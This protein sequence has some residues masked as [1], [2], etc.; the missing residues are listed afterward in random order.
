MRS[1]CLR[2]LLLLSAV[3]IP[4]HAQVQKKA[5]TQA[6]WDRWESIGAPALSNDGR[7]A[8]YTIRPQVGDGRYVV[9][10]T[11]GTTEYTIPL[12]YIA[13]ANN[14]VP[15]R[16]AAGGG[17][18]AGGAAAGGSGQLTSDG[19]FAI[20]TTQATKAEVDRIAK[21]VAALKNAPKPAA[22]APP[23]AAPDTAT[24]KGALVILDLRTGV[25]TAITGA[26]SPRL[27]KESSNWMIYTPDSVRVPGDSTANGRG[28]AG[29]AGGRG[30]GGRGAAGAAASTGPRRTYG[31][32]IV[33]RNMVTG[34]EEKMTY[35]ASSTFDDSAKVLVYTIASRDSTQDGIF[36]RNLATGTTTTVMKQPGNYRGFN[37]DRAQ[38]QF[39]FTTDAGAEFGKPE[40]VGTIY[41]GSLKTGTATAL[42][43]PAMVPTGLRI[44]ATTTATFS[45][46]GTALQFTM[47]PPAPD[48]IP[49]DSLNGK[50]RFDLW[51]WKDPQLQP[52][53]LLSAGRD[54]T[55]SYQT[56]FHLAMAPAAKKP[57]KKGDTT[58]VVGDKR[59]V[60]LADDTVSGVQLS[61][62]AKVGVATSSVRYDIEKMWGGG[63]NDIYI[64][65]PVTGVRRQI[66]AQVQTAGQLSPDAKYA[67]YFDKGNWYAYQLATNK[68]L[69]VTAQVKGVRFD[70]ETWST[71]DE[72]AA[73]G[74]AGWTKGDKSVL[75]YDRFD[76]WELDPTGV[77]APVMV[78]DSVGRREQLSFRLVDLNRDREE[79]RFLDPA[80]PL[81]FR[82]FSE[83]TK[84]SGFYRDR[85]DAKAV[86]EKII[87]GD[88]AY[89]QPTKA[90]GADVYAMTRGTFIEFPNL[91]VGPSLTQMT[92][93]TD[94]NPWQKEYNWGTAELVSWLSEDGV[95]LQGI[96]YKPENFD[97]S[98]KYPL[99]AYNY[100]DLSDGLY[101][102]VPPTGRNIINATHYASNGYLVFMPD[103]HYAEGHPGESA[104]KSIVP[105]VQMLLARGYVDPKGLGIQGQSWGGYQAAYIITQTNLFSAAM[106]GAPV[107]NMTSAYGGIRWGSGL[108]R[109]FQYEKG[110]SRIG[111]SL[112]EAQDLY[113]ENSPLFHLQRVTTPLFIM[114]NDQDDAVPWWQ[115]IEL[116]VGMRRLNKE[117]YLINYNG[118]VHN[119]ASRANQKDIA[120]RMQQF[121]D[122]KLKGMPAPD[123]MVKGIPAVD[124]G[125]D[126]VTFTAPVPPAKP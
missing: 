70:Q 120:M 111:K 112:W 83:A 66:A 71:P 12:G 3:V 56:I 77:K 84:G 90:K 125:R 119:P 42:I 102:Y 20:A 98:K 103:I 86:P 47:S 22:G 61:D 81:Y 13:R 24:P 29:A 79:D 113:L 1:R 2:A 31:S 50:A 122:N 59:L 15:A 78:T 106:A 92:K 124:K 89:G 53:Q 80:K 8:A 110:Q 45:R 62:D 21:A 37:F 97:P 36:I 75:I 101:S 34:A 17:A 115:G 64:V 11:T 10:A 40:P 16:G 7:W 109:A 93:I 74:V 57:A 118:D 85:L 68:L 108:A 91:W 52:A 49:A 123:W 28:A 35:V 82:A 63:G 4:L 48:T 54:R 33:L 27:A 44:P 117:V 87:F 99:I 67:Y 121:F 25:Q 51:H 5:L 55:K 32:T 26:R 95:P 96:L 65:D 69:N 76:V 18:P 94:L 60:K 104:R 41:V 6:D 114:A 126:Q 30:A 116:F 72:P 105:G 19:R 39:V 46:N 100:E 73:W 43:T 14:S 88:Y 38:Q 107:S 9:R 58:T 23:A